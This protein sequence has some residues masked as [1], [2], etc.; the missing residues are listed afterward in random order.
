MTHFKILIDAVTVILGSGIAVTLILHPGP[1]YRRTLRALGLFVVFHNLLV[2][3]DLGYRYYLVNITHNNISLFSAV[4]FAALLVVRIAADTG[5]VWFLFVVTRRFGGRKP[6]RFLLILLLAAG[7]LVF[8]LGIR[9]INEY[10]RTGSLA[11][12]VQVLQVWILAVLGLIF[13]VLAMALWVSRTTGPAE[14]R[15]TLRRLAVVLLL[16]YVLIL[17]GELDFYYF[18]IEVFDPGNLPVLAVNLAVLAWLLLWAPASWRGLPTVQMNSLEHLGGTFGI[19]PR[20]REVIEQLLSGKSNKEIQEALFI[21]PS[22]VKNH[23]TNIYRK[24]GVD[25]RTRLVAM[26]RTRAEDS[27]QP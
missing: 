24:L 2:L 5:S 25:S 4:L 10:G 21:S 23:L 17:F 3:G 20:E 13:V 1:R 18:R 16:A 11:G 19:S 9:G 15:G 14:D 12:V 27:E 7:A 26:L 6:G 8:G 22:T